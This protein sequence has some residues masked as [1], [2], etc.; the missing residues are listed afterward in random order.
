MQP[1]TRFKNRVMGRLKK[2][3]GTWW[4]KI[5]QVGKRGTPDILGCVRCAKCD[6]GIFV[7]LE[8]KTDEGRLAPIQEAKLEDIKKAGGW[9]GVLAPSSMELLLDLEEYVRDY[10]KD[11]GEGAGDVGAD[12]PKRGAGRRKQ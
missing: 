11:D 4:E 12:K 5:Q 7:A 6:R 10:R 3:P 8:L 2:L 1:E 9:G